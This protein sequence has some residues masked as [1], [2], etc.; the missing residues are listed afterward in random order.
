[1]FAGWRA[2]TTAAACET[3]AEGESFWTAVVN[4]EVGEP[5]AA[6][7]GLAFAGADIWRGSRSADVAV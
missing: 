1:M 3:A 4:R 2:G 7:S 6:F 5:W